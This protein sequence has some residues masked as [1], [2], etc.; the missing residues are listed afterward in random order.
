MKGDKSVVFIAWFK[1]WR[2]GEH[3]LTQLSGRFY[4]Q[5]KCE[6]RWPARNMTAVLA[7][8][9]YFILVLA[10]EL[11]ELTL[12]SFSKRDNRASCNLCINLLF[13][14]LFKAKVC[15]AAQGGWDGLVTATLLNKLQINYLNNFQLPTLS[16]AVRNKLFLFWNRSVSSMEK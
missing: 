12:L 5:D 8:H 1:P 9:E 10:V 11:R 6:L 14:E 15:T 13:W 16:V 3:Q 4:L 7:G 2:L